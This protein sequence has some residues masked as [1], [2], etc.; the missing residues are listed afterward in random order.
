MML[1]AAFTP[2][3]ELAETLPRHATLRRYI[4]APRFHA[5]RRVGALLQPQ[6]LSAFAY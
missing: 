3:D 1:I 6:P 5:V 2:C 4:D